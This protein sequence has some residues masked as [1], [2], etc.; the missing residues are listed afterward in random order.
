MSPRW[1]R[2]LLC[3][4]GVLATCW[5]APGQAEASHFRSGNL[6]Y[7]IIGTTGGQTEVEVTLRIYQRRS[8]HCGRAADGGGS[9]C[10]T[11]S[12]NPTPCLGRTLGVGGTFEWGAGVK[13]G[14]GTTI[15]TQSLTT[16]NM[17]VF[18]DDPSNDALGFEV[19]LRRQYPNNPPTNV[20]TTTTARWFSCC[21]ISGVIPPVSSYEL[22]ILIQVGTGNQDP[23]FNSPQLINA[24]AG[25]ALTYNLNPFDPDNDPFTVSVASA[26]SGDAVSRGL[27]ISSAGIINWSSPVAGLWILNV[28]ATDSKGATAN[29]AFLLN[30]T[31]TCSNRNPVMSLSSTSATV[32]VG[33]TASTTVRG[34]DPDTGNLLTFR[35]TPTLPGVTLN[36][37][38]SLT[39]NRPNPHSFTYS[40]T[41]LP[42]DEGRAIS[43]LMSVNDN[44]SPSLGASQT[45]TINVNK[46]DPTIAIAPVGNTKTVRENDVLTFTATAADN[47]E[48][49]TFTAT[50]LPSFCTQAK[51]GNVITV[52]CRPGPTNGGQSYK[53]T[54]T[55]TDKAGGTRTE[56]VTVV[57]TNLNRAPTLTNPGDF[58]IDAGKP[59]QFTITGSDPDGDT[60]TWTFANG[61]TGSSITGAGNV[62]TFNWTPALNQV[63]VF[64][65]TFTI[66]DNG[67]PS[68]STSRTVKIT[69][70]SVNRA[71]ALTNPGD[72]TVDEGKNLTFTITGSDPDNNTLTWTITGTPTGATITGTNTRTFNWTPSF[73]QAGVYTV[74]FAILDNG[75][76]PLGA[77]RSVKITVRNINRPPSFSGTPPTTAIAE[78]AYTYTPSASDPDAGDTLTYKKTKGPGTIDPSTGKVDWT[79]GPS[80]AEK[81]F[82]FEIEVCDDGTPQQCVTQSWKVKVSKPN[83]PPQI[84]GVPPTRLQDTETLAYSPTVRDRDLPND[85]HTWKLTKGP[86]S[87]TIDASTG[88][89]AWTPAAA[90]VGKDIEFSVEVCDKGGLCATQTWKVRVTKG[91]NNPIIVGIP[92]T[93]ANKDNLYNYKPKV[94]DADPGDTHT[95]KLD[96]APSSASVD[97]NTGEVFWKP[98]ARDVGTSADFSLTVCDKAGACTTQTWKVRVQD[99]NDPPSISGTPGTTA[100]VGNGY[101]Y[102][103]KV[104]D[105]N[106]KD[107]HTWTLDKAPSGATIDPKTGKIS[108]TPAAGDDGKE[109][110]FSAR[111]CDNN[112]AC[113]TQTWKV[114]V[115]QGNTPPIIDGTPLVEGE[116]GKAYT[117]APKVT[118]PDQNA[119]HTWTLGKAPAGA[120]VDPKT[121]QISW[122]PPAGSAGK[123]FTFELT[124]C[125]DKGSCA[126][127][128]WTV[129]VKSSGGANTPPVISSL[130]STNANT[131]KQY[132]YD[133]KVTDPDQGDTHTYT[134]E[135][136]PTGMTVDASTGKLSWTPAAAD[137]GKSVEVS[138]KVCDKAGDCATQTWRVKVEQGNNPPQIGGAPGNFATTSQDYT[139]NPTVI[140]PDTDDQGKHKWALKKGPTGATVDPNTGALKWRPKAADVGK[141]FEFTVEVC[142]ASGACAERTWLVLVSE[143]DINNPPVIVS[144]P[145][146]KSNEGLTYGYKPSAVDPDPADT[147]TWK[148][149]NAPSGATI[150]PATGEVTWTPGASD[151]GKSASF[152]IEVCDDKGACDTQTWTVSVGKG[153][154]APSIPST[155]PT[156][157]YVGEKMTYKAQ[158]SDADTGDTHTWTMLKGPAGATVDPTTGEVTW[159]PA[160]ADALTEAEFEI[161]VCDSAVPKSCTTQ[162]FKVKVYNRCKVD[163]ECPTN[164]ICVTGR[165]FAPGCSIANPKCPQGEFCLDSACVPDKCAN[166][167]CQAGEIC[168]PTDGKC[169]KPCAGVTCQS[170]EKCV[171]G[172]CTA[173]PCATAGANGGPCAAGEICDTSD[174]SGAKC[175]KDPCASGSCKHGRVCTEG[176][177]IDDPCVTMQCPAKEQRC[178]AGQCID[179]KPCQVDA[180]CPSDEVCLADGKCYPA[181]CYDTA[182][183]CSGTELCLESECKTDPCASANCGA[184]EFC[185]R[186]DGKCIKPCAGVTCQSGEKCIDGA[187]AKDPCDGVSCQAGEVCV[188]GTCEGERCNASGVCKAGRVC[189]PNSNS[190]KDDPCASVTC[191]DPKQVCEFGQCNNPPQ[192]QFDKDCP[193]T[194][195]CISGKCVA[196]TC[197]EESACAENE[198]CSNGTCAKDPCEGVT[199]KEGEYCKAGKCVGTCAGVFCP[200][201]EKCVDGSCAADPCADKQ[202]AAGEVCINGNCVTNPCEQDS[203]RQGRLCSP[204]GRCVEDPCK[205]IKCPNGQTCSAGQCGGDR[206]CA[207]DIDCPG[208]AICE[209]G[210]C[211]PKGCYDTKCADGEVC[212]AGSCKKNS[213]SG[214]TCNEGETCRPIDGQCAKN[215]PTCPSGQRCNQGACEADPCDGKTCPDGE[216]CVNGQCVA[217]SCKTSDGSKPCKYVRTCLGG[218]CVD[219][220]CA[221][222]Q[223]AEDE[224]CR[225]G[226]CYGKK[227]VEE[228]P[229]TTEPTIVDGGNADGG[230]TERE[231]L[232]ASGGCGCQQQG[233]TPIGFGFV[234]LLVFFGFFAARRRTH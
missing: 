208:D 175:V 3:W 22:K 60:L 61:A 126:T 172:A 47:G 177:C 187:C 120:T 234:L 218:T 92:G 158:V 90:D 139:F 142:D 157:A 43:V 125:D 154:Q 155:P 227:V 37:A 192:C 163:S 189:D 6:S 32:N 181:G 171:D 44:G 66:K 9:C 230:N 81:E 79:P 4:L 111:V 197:T 216:L 140:D 153:N 123:S 99:T 33:Q 45:F 124:V 114:R 170:G 103:P 107:T 36:P 149:K 46:Q 72:F 232:L 40:Y 141:T 137:A 68:L 15:G 199:C 146:T 93:T 209:S 110:E 133:I 49:D 35:I 73:T 64:N 117:Y 101:S 106:T 191:P 85:T 62:K 55:A 17:K 5:L 229:T 63:G 152:E 59:L 233:S 211:K 165:C 196:P 144:T 102:E 34:S 185:R 127:Q 53:I 42:A 182:N 30:V 20:T 24:C 132:E 156:E 119:T 145:G 98:G 183:K 180:D 88:K 74:N 84:I 184:G 222:V 136:G 202:C 169:I 58:T 176:R 52:V 89:V 57:V 82:D 167:N 225:L 86:S 178:V 138:V 160:A 212:L 14:G 70:L 10:A 128:T 195:L 76:P 83:S 100:S 39:A 96:K 41:A 164:E 78:T 7:R 162:S 67:T 75:T 104:V 113:A 151:V 198:L 214:V 134:L 148:L 25:R 166:S 69:V 109:V 77:T 143:G 21:Y 147:L 173:D 200:T 29:R 116:E 51:V 71:P 118:D 50:G 95:W 135:K 87:A 130:P 168:R 105:A 174:A 65:V 213:C 16:T 48:I 193:G 186:S 215:C 226:V 194:Q 206:K 108:W 28:T 122:T 161:Q 204:E 207:L 11:S 112:G 38:N 97:P 56:D 224:T 231:P 205:G 80:D 2:F 27:T 13:Q 19:K 190:C 203:C 54:F 91:N 121:G 228:P 26:G 18:D 179:R 219:D 220:P 159:T 201:G 12:S 223:C 94:S 188:E 217:D 31:N 131:G 210:V 221:G 150:D 8:S 129:K 115:G 1:I 23:D